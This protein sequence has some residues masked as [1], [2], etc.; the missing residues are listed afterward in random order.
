MTLKLKRTPGLYL[1]GFM[2]SGKS[3]IGRSLADELGWNFVDIDQEIEHQQGVTI[4]EIFER[5]GEGEFRRIESEA[6]RSRV[7]LIERGRPMVLAL[8]GGAFA[9]AA[10]VELLENN[11]VT[12]WLDCPFPLVRQRV[13]GATHRPLARDPVKLEALY[14]ERRAF[15]SKADYRIEIQ[16]DDPAEAVAAILSLPIF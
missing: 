4:A 12:V 1:V 15:Y 5:R 2:G 9:Q 11:G 14:F 6:I 13:A 8:G 7:R 3:T 16:N 10:N